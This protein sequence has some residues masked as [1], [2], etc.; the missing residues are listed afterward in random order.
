[1]T[2]L[3]LTLIGFFTITLT[4]G[5]SEINNIKS[6]CSL[7]DDWFRSCAEKSVLRDLDLD[8]ASLPDWRGEFH[9]NNL[10]GIFFN[11]ASSKT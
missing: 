9:H 2:K 1:M 3:V 4:F 8:F 6:K 7:R 11:I 10:L 5:Q